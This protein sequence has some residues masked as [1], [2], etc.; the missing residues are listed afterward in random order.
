[1]GTRKIL[2]Q[3]SIVGAGPHRS[4]F[5]N[6]AMGFQEPAP[7]RTIRGQG[8]AP[9]WWV[10]LAAVAVV[11]W[12]WVDKR[13]DPE[14]EITEAPPPV[15]EPVAPTADPAE[16]EKIVHLEE[17]LRQAQRDLVEQRQEIEDLEARLEQ[18]QTDADLHR[19]GLERAVEELN[20]VDEELVRLQAESSFQPKSRFPS[21]PAEK[22]RIMGAPFVSTSQ[23]GFVVASGM[24]HNPGDYSVR[25]TLEVSLVGSGG[26]MDTRGFLMDLGPGAT[27]RYDITFTNIFPTE[28]LG[29]QA[30]W[31]E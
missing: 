2:I 30:R 1:M 22:V 13:S 15:V 11:A 6:W 5:Y 24:V 3:P 31:V 12:V 17:M 21:P 10:T 19:L 7:R 28:R 4:V 29:A 25:G 18:A 20:R 8:I 16:V 23:F 26:V 9:A 27:E 14:P